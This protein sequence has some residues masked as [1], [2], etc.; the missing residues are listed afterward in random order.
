MEDQSYWKGTTSSELTIKSAYASIMMDRWANMKDI[1]LFSW[2]V[3]HKA[4]LT[5]HQRRLRHITDNPSYDIYYEDF[6]SWEHV[7]QDCSE[8]RGMWEEVVPSTY[9]D[10]F[11]FDH[12][13]E[14]IIHNL[15]DSSVNDDRTLW[16]VIFNVGC[17][18]NWKWRNH[19]IFTQKMAQR[20]AY[21]VQ[22]MAKEYFRIHSL[23]SA[24]RDLGTKPEILLGWDKPLV[25]K[26]KLNTDSAVNFESKLAT[27][28]RVIRNNSREWIGGF[29]HNI[30]TSSV[31]AAELW[32]IFNGLQLYQNNGS[33]RVDVESDN[34]TVVQFILCKKETNNQVS[35]LVIAIKCLLR[36]Q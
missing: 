35:A 14:W 13:D 9:Q 12:L 16:N 36:R 28:G 11:F 27:A 19:R 18:L 7:L 31:L 29:F 3:L 6:K 30:G 25:D 8:S 33:K 10:Y 15:M 26:I 22:T 20:K 23:M 24:A 4:I 21:Q 2:F 17:W 32:G 34:F 1:K 5:N